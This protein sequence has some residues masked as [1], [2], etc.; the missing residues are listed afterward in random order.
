MVTPLLI[1]EVVRAWAPA[2]IKYTLGKQQQQQNQE[3]WVQT[4]TRWGRPEWALSWSVRGTTRHLFET[5]KNE[6]RR[7][8]YGEKQCTKKERGSR[9]RAD[10]CLDFVFGLSQVPNPRSELKITFLD[11]LASPLSN[12][13]QL[14]MNKSKTSVNFAENEKFSKWKS[15]LQRKK[16]P[17]FWF[18]FYLS[19]A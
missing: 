5:W 14:L 13:M 11:I 3:R 7:K 10:M 8:C 4:K 6:S 17:L 19:L 16:Y 9:S 15:L 1:T 18:L 2:G 12:S